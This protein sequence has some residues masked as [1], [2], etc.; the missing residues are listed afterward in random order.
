VGFDVLRLKECLEKAEGLD[1]AFARRMEGLGN[2]A[3][4]VYWD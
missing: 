3:P 2:A 1:L 4:Q